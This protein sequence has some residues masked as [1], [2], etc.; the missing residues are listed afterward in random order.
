MVAHQNIPLI[1][2]LKTKLSIQ[3]S[4]GSGRLYHFFSI[5]KWEKG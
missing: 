2:Q 1:C 4:K 3:E 5:R